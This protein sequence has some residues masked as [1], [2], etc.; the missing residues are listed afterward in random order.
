[1]D[2]AVM[3]VLTRLRVMTAVLLAVERAGDGGT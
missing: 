2:P 1:M 3:P